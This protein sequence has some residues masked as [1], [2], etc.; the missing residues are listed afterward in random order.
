MND[1]TFGCEFEF[2]DWDTRKGWEPF[3]RD[4]ETAICNSNGIS[5]DPT[6][7]SY[8]FGGEV[9]TA[10]THDPHEQVAQLEMFLKMHPDAAL[11]HRAGLQVH[12]RVP[13]LIKDLKTLKRIQDYVSRNYHIFPLVDPLPI[14]MESDYYSKEEWKAAKKRQH[15]MRTSHWTVIP[16]YR[17]EEQLKAKTVQEFLEAE[18]PRSKKGKVLWHAQPRASINLRQLLQTDT[19]EFRHWSGTLNSIELLNAIEYC[20]DYLEDAI[21]SQRGWESLWK[22]YKGLAFPKT[23]PFYYWREKRWEATSITKHKRKV[24]EENIK[25]ILNGTFDEYP[26]NGPEPKKRKG[27]F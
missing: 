5:A 21:Y 23:F 19:I 7:K 3:R 14:P 15:W 26:E 6:L 27:L 16:R 22:K 17:V 20:R 8:P 25:K 9:C 2:A 12:I 13:G 11:T 1:W 10:P 18:A 4:P 24:I